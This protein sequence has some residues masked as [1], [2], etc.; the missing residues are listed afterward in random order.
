MISVCLATYNGAQYIEEQL[1]SILIQLAIDDEVIV[2]DNGSLDDTVLKIQNLKDDRIKII[3]KSIN[4][5]ITK[6]DNVTMNFQNALAVAKG[7]YIFLSDQDDIWMPTKVSSCLNALAKSTLVVHDC[8]VV[9]KDLKI[10]YNSYFD[11]INVGSGFWK[12]FIKMRYLGCCIAFRKELLTSALPF[13]HGI[14]HDSWICL[15]NELQYSSYCLKEPLV[16][17]RRHDFNASSASNASS[18]SLWFKLKHRIPMLFKPVFRVIKIWI[19]D[20]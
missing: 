9:N 14:A 7:D 5:N 12:N 11:L 13:V 8:M 19:Y 10:M 2:S 18:T 17:Y 6:A 3:H 1:K 4:P 15:V 16:K 20:I